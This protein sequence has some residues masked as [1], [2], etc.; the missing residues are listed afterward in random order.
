M[1]RHEMHKILQCPFLE[2]HEKGLPTFEWEH[3]AMAFYKIP[4]GLASK[5]L[6]NVHQKIVLECKSK[7]EVYYFGV[8]LKD[9]ENISLRKLRNLLKFGTWYV[10]TWAD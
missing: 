5:H 4:N 2:R 1:D 6:L 3:C 8:G 10:Y 7:S 9:C